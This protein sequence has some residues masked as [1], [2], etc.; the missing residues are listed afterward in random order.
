MN[1]KTLSQL[2]RQQPPVNG[3]TTAT[4][5]GRAMNDKWDYGEGFRK[6]F[7][8]KEGGRVDAL[9]RPTRVVV[10]LKP[11]NPRQIRQGRQQLQG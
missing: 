1:A 2:E 9:N 7:T 5:L 10:E 11:N 8:L 4:A 3:E 6:E